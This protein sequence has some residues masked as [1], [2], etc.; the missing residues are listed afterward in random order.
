M[1]ARSSPGLSAHHR[2][3]S[4]GGKA[5]GANAYKGKRSPHT[6]PAFPDT[7]SVSKWTCVLRTVRELEDCPMVHVIIRKSSEL[8]SS[9]HTSAKDGGPD[10]DTS[11]PHV[12]CRPSD[13]DSSI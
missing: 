7:K 13:D 12:F 4:Q 2:K 3:G 9:N 5:H 8:R 11:A 6:L 10:S 1:Q